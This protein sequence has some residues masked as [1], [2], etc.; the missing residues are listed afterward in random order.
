MRMTR[1]RGAVG[2]GEGKAFVGPE[3]ACS[4]ALTFMITEP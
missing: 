4:A 1:S 2:K 3:L